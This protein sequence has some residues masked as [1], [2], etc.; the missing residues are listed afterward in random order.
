MIPSEVDMERDG[1]RIRFEV[2]GVST[3]WMDADDP[4]VEIIDESNLNR[5]FMKRHL[6]KEIEM[7]NVLDEAITHLEGGRYDKAI[8]DFDAVLFYDPCC[9][10]ALLGKS[11]ALFGQK[12]FVKALRNY[13]KAVKASPYLKDLEYHKALLE[14]SHEERDSFAPFKRHIYAGDEHFARKEFEKALE[15]Y[16]KAQA[17]LS[18]AKKK[19]L[20]K[21]LNKK[22][23]THLELN[24]FE[25]AL[26]CFN[27]SL[28]ELNNDFAWYGKGLSEYGLGLDASE[29]L[30]HAV[31]LDKAQLLE[32]ALVLNEIEDYAQALGT[33]DEILDNHFRV[34]D[35]YFRAMNAKMYAM[36]K[37]DMDLSE[38]ENVFDVLAQ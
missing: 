10:E 23:A 8:G 18:A 20:F 19:I 34:D 9:G 22:G 7:R 16:E 5:A 35:F 32:K 31:K 1:D 37:L 3:D 38:I 24:D 21:L 14:K 33:C 17:S 25:S 29:S 13:K 15:N 2:D 36:R 11:H 6:L 28:N 27:E 12:H 4:F 30:T 26:M